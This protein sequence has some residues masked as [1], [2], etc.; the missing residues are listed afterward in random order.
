MLYLSA[1]IERWCFYCKYFCQGKLEIFNCLQIP[2]VK[3]N[4]LSLTRFLCVE[5]TTTYWEY[6]FNNY[7]ESLLEHLSSVTHPPS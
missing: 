7:A 3:K 2:K 5:K 1:N 4:S 6:R